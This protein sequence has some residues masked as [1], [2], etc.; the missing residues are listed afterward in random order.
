[1]DNLRYDAQKVYPRTSDRPGE[2]GGERPQGAIPVV[3]R[4]GSVWA[5]LGSRFSPAHPVPSRRHNSATDISPRMPSITMR[6]LSSVGNLRRVARLVLRTR[7][8]AVSAERV[9]PAIS[10]GLLSGLFSSGMF[11]LPAPLSPLVL[12]PFLG[13]LNPQMCSLTSGLKLSHFR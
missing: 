6:I 10:L 4:F 3:S 9:G 13:E 11:T 2:T 1:M 5:F 7:A 12:L 8:R